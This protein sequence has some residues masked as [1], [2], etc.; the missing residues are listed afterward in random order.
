MKLRFVLPVT[1]FVLASVSGCGAAAPQD[2]AMRVELPQQFRLPQDDLVRMF[3]RRSGRIAIAGEDGNLVVMDQTGG[4]V[5]RITRDGNIPIRNAQRQALQPAVSSALRTRYVLP[6]WSPDASHI[7]FVELKAEP[8]QSSAI[9]ELN[10]AAVSVRR[11]EDTVTFERTERGTR[12]SQD[13]ARTYVEDAPSRVIIERSSS[14]EFFSSALYV[15][16]ADGKGPLNELYESRESGVTY[17]DWSPD[18]RNIAF[19]AESS[20]ED[21]V[22]LNLVNRDGSAKPQQ[23]FEGAT[24]AWHWSMDGKT[25]AANLNATGRTNDAKLRLFDLPT[26][27]ANKPVVD[28]APSFRAPQ[29]APGGDRMLLTRDEGS[30]MALVLAD[31]NGNEIRQLT[32]FSG[33]ISFAWSPIPGDPRL[34]YITRQ[35]ESQRGGPLRLLDTD[36]GEE[37]VLSQLPVAAF[38]WS[39]DAVRIAMFSPVRVSDITPDFPGLDLTPDAP[40]NPYMLHMIDTKTRGTRQLYFFEPTPS[41]ERVI[42]EFDQFSRSLSIWSPDS[43]R[44]VFPLAFNNG[45]TT[46]NFVIESEASGSI[47]PRVLGNGTMAVWSP[48]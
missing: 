18:S 21:K 46:Q 13:A 29:F 39:P 9:I 11:G 47:N 30:R 7:A 17:L 3:E 2:S 25:L 5:T 22:T 31:R 36:T 19:V 44:I 48:R 12:Q 8:P 32:T 40:T 1:A 35:S 6:I 45:Q 20:T 42:G 4:G 43:L 10:P 24:A 23:L 28:T 15:A 26:G 33:R 16:S 34:A 38:F 27:A 14:G 41:F 37:T